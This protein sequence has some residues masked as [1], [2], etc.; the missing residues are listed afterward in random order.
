MWGS[1]LL[2]GHLVLTILYA[3]SVAYDSE[4]KGL[5]LPLVTFIAATLG[6]VF[7][8][9]LFATLYRDIEESSMA[10]TFSSD[11]GTPEPRLG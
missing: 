4:L 7:L 11:P 6:Q 8:W 5:V 2:A 9:G 1:L 3:I 10:D